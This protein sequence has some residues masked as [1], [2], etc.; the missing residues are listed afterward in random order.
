[1]LHSAIILADMM[2]INPCR[3]VFMSGARIDKGGRGLTSA[4]VARDWTSGLA[5]AARW[6]EVRRIRVVSALGSTRSETYRLSHRFYLAETFPADAR[7]S[8]SVG[9]A[10]CRRGETSGLGRRDAPRSGMI[11]SS[12]QNC[13]LARRNPSA[14]S[15]R[16]DTLGKL[17]CE[18]C[19]DALGGTRTPMRATFL[20]L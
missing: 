6:I 9:R 16:L 17:Q 12:P 5:R 19:P 13:R 8:T 3:L 1:M 15:V 18:R 2:P 10:T 20:Q 11:P 14:E 4:C 7:A